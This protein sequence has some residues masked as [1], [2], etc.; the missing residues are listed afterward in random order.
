MPAQYQRSGS[1][2]G[3]L[4]MDN[5]AH[6]TGRKRPRTAAGDM[7]HSRCSA[8]RSIV[9]RTLAALVA[10]AVLIGVTA[11]SG[12]APKI[13][14][15]PT[16][17]E[18]AE[19]PDTTEDVTSVDQKSAQQKDQPTGGS[20]PPVIAT[21]EEEGGAGQPSGSG[22]RSPSV[23]FDGPTTGMPP[24]QP[25]AVAADG[26][27]DAR[28]GGGGAPTSASPGSAAS[29]SAGASD[30]D[31]RRI[32]DM[33]GATRGLSVAKKRSIEA[34]EKP[35]E[36]ASDWSVVPVF[37]GTDRS[38]DDQPERIAYDWQRGR[39]LELGR[40]LV[41]I[42]KAHEV[43]KVER[44]WAIRIPYTN[45]TLYEAA[46]DPKRHFTIQQI[47]SLD[48]E[49]F[50]GFVKERLAKSKTFKDH[51]LVFVHGYQTQFDNAIYRTAQITYD[52]DFD[53]APFLYS[54]PSGGTLQGYTYDRE[55]AAQAEPY[56]REFL[57]M[58]AEESGAKS[59]SVI[60][61]SMGNQVT[62]R[63]LQ[64][65][66]RSL[67]DELK[68]SQLILAAPDVDRDSFENI[69]GSIIGI[70]NGITL[71]SAANDKALAIS[72]RVNGGV[73]RAGDVPVEG[74]L[75]VSGVDTIDATATS[76]DS[77]GINHSGYAESN[78]LLQDISLLIR[79]GQR[80]PEARLPTLERITTDRGD[81][82]KY[83]AQ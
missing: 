30:V 17:T 58:V 74:P 36:A 34:S 50:L 60:A 14:S 16:N 2:R 20:S 54:W 8:E 56:L 83:P 44:P 82:W 9:T 77:I 68:L 19:V 1:V 29:D 64:D 32:R 67:P 24:Q 52:M 73:P 26:D 28:V 22:P 13:G 33:G 69:V 23:A 70:A 41:T 61:H 31:R 6:D 38:R 78:A 47:Q 37:Y 49:G 11:C 65:L 62:L 21:D 10:G 76:M 43:P 81:Y 63:V 80:P 4:E 5:G 12:E 18:T 25:P 45:I 59:V 3:K 55:S 75:I 35:A 48:K 7:A 15:A 72:R 71:Y 42:P 27:A 40:A 39:R 79:T 57:T 51:A 66:R 46:E 53:G